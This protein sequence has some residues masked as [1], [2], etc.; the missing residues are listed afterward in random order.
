MFPVVLGSGHPL[1]LQWK[2]EMGSG[3]S[4]ILVVCSS[5]FL[6]QEVIYKA[7]P[8]SPNSLPPVNSSS[9]NNQGSE[10]KTL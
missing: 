10:W 5:K 2:K 9:I 4:V 3:E 1:C 8:P 7:F 6:R